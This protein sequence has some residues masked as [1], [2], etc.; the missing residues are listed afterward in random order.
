MT[1]FHGWASATSRRKE[2]R[3][4]RM[5]QG[6]G[7]RTCIGR[8][9]FTSAMSAPEHVRGFATAAARWNCLSARGSALGS[10]GDIIG[11][12]GRA[13]GS[14]ICWRGVARAGQGHCNGWPGASTIEEGFERGKK[15]KAIGFTAPNSIRFRG[16]GAAMSIGRT[17]IRVD[18]CGDA[19]GV[20]P[21]FAILVEAHRRSRRARPRDRI[22]Q[23]I[24]ELASTGREH[25][26]RDNWRYRECGAAV[27]LP[28]VTA[29]RYTPRKQYSP[30]CN[31][32]RRHIEPDI[33]RESGGIS[34]V[35]TSPRWRSRRPCSFAAINSNS[36][37][38]GMGE[39]MYRR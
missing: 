9:V 11:R 4:S 14:T 12:A 2:G 37:L 34:A 1:G 24:V 25:M 3:Y 21:D 35:S 31:A 17:R 39:S 6:D 15:I 27:P 26:H 5:R 30:A 33:M 22:G 7:C 8:S 19:R 29:R 28:L 10:H 13:A 20:W 18:L 23:R 38:I 36:P 16:R 32:R